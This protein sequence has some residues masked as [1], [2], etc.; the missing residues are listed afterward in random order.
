MFQV[1]E[2]VGDYEI[3]QVLGAGGMGQ[4]YKVRNTLSDRIEAMKV[5]LPGL[6]GDAQL[7]DRFLREIKVQASLI[8]KNIAQL[9]TAQR[10]GDQ[11]LMLLEFVD[12][13]TLESLMKRGALTTEATVNLFVQVLDALSFAHSRGVVHRDIKPANIMVTGDG[14]AKLMDFGIARVAQDKRLTQTGRTLGSLY[15]M[16]PEQI[17]G[18]DDIDGRSDLYSLGVTLYE[19]ATGARPFDGDSDYTIMAA[20][21]QQ[22]PVP[23]VERDP[24]LPKTLSDVILAAIEKDR[25]QR[26]QSAEAFKGALGHVKSG[27]GEFSS[28]AATVVSAP[29]LPPPP[30]QS[31]VRNP[32][33]P[34]QAP[35]PV[36]S[37][38]PPYSPPMPPPSAT[39]HRKSSAGLFMAIGALAFAALG[40]V[41]YWQYPR[42]FGQKHVT[43]EVKPADPGSTPQQTEVK[44]PEPTKQEPTSQGG[45]TKTAEQQ[46]PNVPGTDPKPRPIEPTT[47]AGSKPAPPP[48]P[49]DQQPQQPVVQTPT[50]AT[51]AKQLQEPQIDPAV[52]K[53]LE[54]LRQHY[55]QLSIRLTGC[56]EGMASLEAQQRSMGVGL[57]GDVKEAARNAEYKMR[58]AMG[59]I[60]NKDV[61]AARTDLEAAERM[62]DFVGKAVGR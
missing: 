2:R 25:D 29:P 18:A 55:N 60:R 1:G 6:V 16:S 51:P 17:R 22:P 27:P 23:P 14:T 31:N 38:P 58:E 15:Y 33:T 41:G 43:E 49:V 12:G 56:K 34:M 57:R 21:L 26:F 50:Y 36:F 46:K 62:I 48:Q 52:A 19:A 5:L 47:T 59:A 45:A 28:R 40:G 61:E 3:M 13:V 4:V 24:R 53:Q 11:I 44:P 10:N 32:T 35:P 42:I 54:E 7:A 8:H 30:H 39:P 37:Q 20:H 9:Y